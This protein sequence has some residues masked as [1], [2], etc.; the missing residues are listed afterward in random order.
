MSINN[1][2]QFHGW[3]MLIVLMV[4]VMMVMMMIMLWSHFAAGAGVEEVVHEHVAVVA[5]SLRASR[6]LVHLCAAAAAPRRPLDSFAAPEALHRLPVCACERLSCACMRAR[7]ALCVCECVC[8]E[9]D[10]GVRGG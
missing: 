4:M 9:S 5:E 3:L 7:V 1:N 10:G 2:E 8:D 6:A